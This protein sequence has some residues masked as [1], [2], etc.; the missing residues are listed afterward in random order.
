MPK[1]SKSPLR[2][3]RSGGAFRVPH[4]ALTLI[5]A[6]SFL[7]VL[8]AVGT[9]LAGAIQTGDQA[10]LDS[11]F[12]NNNDLLITFGVSEVL[13][14][15]IG[16][17]LQR[18][19]A[20]L[21][22]RTLRGYSGQ[23][24]Y[25]SGAAT[26]ISAWLDSAV[27]PDAGGVLPALTIPADGTGFVAVTEAFAGIDTGDLNVITPQTASTWT[28]PVTAGTLTDADK[29][30]LIDVNAN[31]FGITGVAF[32]DFSVKVDF[33]VAPDTTRR[34]VR[35]P[36]IGNGADSNNKSLGTL[37]QNY[38]E[39]INVLMNSSNYVGPNKEALIAGGG[40]IGMSTTSG[41]IVIQD[42]AG[43]LFRNISVKTS[44]TVP[45]TPISAP[46]L[47]GG[48]IIGLD[49]EATA[50]SSLGSVTIAKV[51]DNFF[52]DIIVDITDIIL[53][54]GLVGVHS[55]SQSNSQVAY[56]KLGDVTGNIF[57]TGA[58]AED[59]PWIPIQDWS[60]SVN[61]TYSLRGGGVIGA[62][63]YTNADVEI[64]NV[65]NNLFAGIK[66]STGTYISG[67]G[68]IGLQVNDNDIDS[69]LKKTIDAPEICGDMLMCGLGAGL[70]KANDNA[71]IN[72]SVT[73]GTTETWVGLQGAGLYT[74]GDIEGGGVIGVRSNKGPADMEEVKGNVFRGITVTALTRS[75][76]MTATTKA[77]GNIKGG[78]VIGVH[79]SSSA[80]ISSL[81]DNYFDDIAISAAGFILGGGLVGVNASSVD[82]SASVMQNFTRNSVTDTTVYAAYGITGGGVVGVVTSG[83][84]TFA[85]SV[86]FSDSV[87]KGVTVE[88]DKFIRGGGIIG[89]SG[90]T[91]YDNVLSSALSGNLFED[92]IVNTGSPVSG[93]YSA[94]AASGTYIEGGGVIGLLGN[95]AVSSVKNISANA[96]KNI[97]V[98]SGAYIDGGGIIGVNGRVNTTVYA[99]VETMTD[100][101]F[102]DNR[103]TAENGSIMGGIFYS[104]GL[105]G[106]MTIKNATFK[107]NYFAAV[108]SDQAAY[109]PG[110]FGTGFAAPAVVYGT[111]T[112]DTGLQKAG[113]L[114]NKLTLTA[115]SGEETIFSGNVAMDEWGSGDARASYSIYF[116]GVIGYEDQNPNPTLATQN[117]PPFKLVEDDPESDGLLVIAPEA[118]G[119]VAL[120][121]PIR[122][123]QTKLSDPSV[124]L[125]TFGMEVAGLGEFRWGGDNLFEVKADDSAHVTKNEINFR[126]LSST[127]L[128][129]GMTL[130]AVNH[131]FLME[132]GALLS[133]AGRNGALLTTIAVEEFS[134]VG[135]IHFVLNGEDVN[136][137]TKPLL[138]IVAPAAGGIDLTGATVTL[139]NFALNRELEVGDEF[140]LVDG[141]V[142]S[143]SHAGALTLD[144]DGKPVSNATAT[145]TGVGQAEYLL[146]LDA[147]VNPANI[148]DTAF[149][150][151]ANSGG[152]FLTARI[153]EVYTFNPPPPG[154]VHVDVVTESYSAGSAHISLMGS[155][156]AE[157]SYQ[158]AD[159]AFGAG[160]ARA[161]SAGE[162][163]PS[164]SIFAGVDG[165]RYTVKE[166]ADVDIRGAQAVL[167]A[168]RKIRLDSGEF[169]IG[170]FLEA[171]SFE[172]KVATRLV[173]GGEAAGGNGRSKSA[174]GGLMAR[175]LWNNGFRVEASARA[176]GLANRFTFTELPS[177]HGFHGR[178]DLNTSYLGATLGVGHSFQTTE[179]STLDLVA[180]GYWTR[181]D[182]NSVLVGQDH[183]V[184][185]GTSDAF[186]AR[187]GA[188][189][190]FDAGARARLYVGAYYDREFS[191]GV[192]ARSGGMNLEQNDMRGST[193]I[194]EV[195]AIARPSASDPGFTLSFGVQGFVGRIRG[196]SGGLRAGWEF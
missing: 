108:V 116:G 29:L 41:N 6:S 2:V 133:V 12:I 56:S 158:A 115:S 143:P 109:S 184:D 42:V 112:I 191:H 122:V 61:A 105:S 30:K 10:G 23:D 80:Q 124:R 38:F 85:A 90:Q 194:F 19:K 118:G 104:Y 48:G 25:L 89:M 153:A 40:V 22:G 98:N 92:I 17:P 21:D 67:G 53:G 186:H 167:G 147:E 88:T 65:S 150:N 66:V 73:A 68:I 33:N 141:R 24:Q 5:I 43:N 196:F 138:T 127:V 55:N 123:R 121:D 20:R 74:G 111:V 50:A 145:V 170:A 3:S 156:V 75:P 151:A 47:E 169:L 190:G 177:G 58:G 172:Y 9:A 146:V 149:L 71:F 34:V 94:S 39:N 63:A 182:G 72:I 174:G 139:G 45:S 52:Q 125:G 162:E 166:G 13:V 165:S 152:R 148:P 15:E 161:E 4:A 44:S 107:N 157:H 99:G 81:E 117:S 18:M 142:D 31:N 86:G 126:N 76:S 129:P 28:I 70:G 54:G 135:G 103:I 84:A 26:I 193:G 173:R 160:G 192:D 155:W 110:T 79:S 163:P 37:S 49:M 32:R 183:T 60:I 7:F 132:S 95:G 11:E 175:A 69:Q 131:R 187:A 176:G 16:S 8:A 159:I 93:A 171:G 102:L 78:G 195:G 91:Q 96:F 137:P 154:P 188:K 181:I 27:R 134:S 83:T 144:V 35:N 14:D 189:F 100:N 59:G 136:D 114:P 106:D 82:S 185:F 64:T 51:R 113:N 130:E 179:N 62:N 180:R 77:N 119:A 36:F 46:Y 140:Y 178:Y 128:L 1:H 168:A 120:E 57:G 87:F 164:W 97:T 101:V